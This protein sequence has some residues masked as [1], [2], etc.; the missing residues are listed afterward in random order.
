MGAQQSIHTASMRE[1]L[2]A[3]T[4]RQGSGVLFC[5]ETCTSNRTSSPR[6]HAGPHSL[7]YHHKLSTGT[8]LSLCISAWQIVSRRQTLHQQAR[9]AAHCCPKVCQNLTRSLLILYRLPDHFSTEP[10]GQSPTSQQQKAPCGLKFSLTFTKT[11]VMPTD[12]F[13]N[14]WH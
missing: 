10:C 5:G 4:L 3:C 7:L 6:R 12:L 14:V 2:C 11:L 9:P 1:L 13:R 8:L